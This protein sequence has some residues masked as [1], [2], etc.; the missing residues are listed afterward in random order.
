MARR[1]E[2][3]MVMVEHKRRGFGYREIDQRIYVL[4]PL[5]NI[6]PFRSGVPCSRSRPTMSQFP[7]TIRAITF[8]KTGDINVIEETEQPFP[9]QGPG[10]VILKVHATTVYPLR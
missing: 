6:N 1:I 5:T 10:D 3:E 7:A 8:S 9:K 2:V 4:F